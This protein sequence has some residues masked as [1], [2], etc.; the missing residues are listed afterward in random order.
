METTEAPEEKSAHN[1]KTGVNEPAA[2]KHTPMM[3][4]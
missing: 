3:Q 1:N 2:V 4:Q